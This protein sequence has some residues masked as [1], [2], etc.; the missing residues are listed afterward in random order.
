MEAPALTLTPNSSATSMDLLTSGYVSVRLAVTVT[1]HV[2]FHST[3]ICILWFSYSK[4][5]VK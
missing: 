5:M 3:L 2:S 4:H 1:E